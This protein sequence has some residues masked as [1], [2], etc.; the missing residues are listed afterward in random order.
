MKKSPL[1]R[2][3]KPLK[4]TPLKKQNNES[5]KEKHKKR[6]IQ[7]EEDI[8]FYSEVWEDRKHKS[9][10]TGKWLGEEIMS[11]YFHHLLPKEPFPEFR[12]KKWNILLCEAE[13]HNQIETNPNLLPEEVFDRL[14]I[15]LNKAKEKANIE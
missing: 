10:L 4:K 3:Q 2:N 11:I 13:Y 15:Y 7:K 8:L 5:A 1:K 14:L 9:D 12:H 6:Q